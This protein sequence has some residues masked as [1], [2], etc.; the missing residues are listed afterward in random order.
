MCVCVTH[1][2]ACPLL[3]GHLLL[4]GVGSC[5]LQVEH[6]LEPCGASVDPLTPLIILI[7]TTKLQEIKNGLLPQ[8]QVIYPTYNYFNPVYN[9]LVEAL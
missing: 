5:H 6:G 4:L 8:C 7:N 9:E 2:G 1:V 3:A